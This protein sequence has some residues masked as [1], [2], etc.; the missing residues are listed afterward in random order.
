MIEAVC[1]VL[2]LA[3]VLFG[4]YVSLKVSDA[5]QKERVDTL[6]KDVN[7]AF[8]KIRSIENNFK[9]AG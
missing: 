5:V 4:A 1:A 7:E 8:K 6:R 3:G 9:K 2:G